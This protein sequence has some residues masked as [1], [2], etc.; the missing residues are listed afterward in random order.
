MSKSR[1]TDPHSSNK[2]KFF[3]VFRRIRTPFCIALFLLLSALV[4]L[5]VAY[6]SLLPQARPAF[7][8]VELAPTPSPIPEITPQSTPV[9]TAIPT[10]A[11]APTETP[12]AVGSPTSLAPVY[13]ISY[14]PLKY[15]DDREEVLAL[16][17]RL[18]ELQ[19]MDSDDPTTYFGNATK[20]AVTLFQ[21]SND[22]EATGEADEMTLMLLYSDDAAIYML[23]RND[24]GDDVEGLQD[25][26]NEL[27]Y[28]EERIN[29]YFGAATERALKAFQT[30]NRVV[31]D[32]VA[33]QETRDLIYSPNAKPKIDPTPTP[34]P[35]PS[36]TPRPATT[37]KPSD[38]GSGEGSGGGGSIPVIGSGVDAM[39]QT[40]LAQVG[41]PYVWSKES[42]SE[43]FDCSGLVYFS[44]RSSGI[45]IGRYSASGFS[46]VDRW[47][48]IGSY[49]ELRYGDLLFFK[50]DSNTRISHTGIFLGGNSFVHASS[51]AG[52]VVK[53]TWSDWC[54]RN[55]VHG[56]RVY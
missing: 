2:E 56:R 6:G 43:G 15:E 20:A 11:P 39:V 19:Y 33:G 7:E 53:S 3:S 34:T 49:S 45:S 55:F 28:Y 35:R 13:E 54:A 8:P 24:K 46:Q 47:T 52:R 51:S 18:M 32:G 1:A 42:P 21:R 5:P 38:G 26:L 40:A 12:A 16:Q 17:E 25:R 30:K 29:G 14:E 36:P 50:S 23:K 27:G 9:P 44:L 37:A 10:T 48:Y 31:P 41:K 22:M 4:I